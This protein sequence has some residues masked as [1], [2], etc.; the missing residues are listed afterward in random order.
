MKSE[1]R[2]RTRRS[3]VKY[4]IPSRDEIARNVF[5]ETKWDV[6]HF[7]F[8]DPAMLN[9]DYVL[10]FVPLEKL[11]NRKLKAVRHLKIT[12]KS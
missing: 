9:V 4:V 2:A 7:H 1:I 10:Y 6:N 8:F 5:P 11:M 12:L 3:C